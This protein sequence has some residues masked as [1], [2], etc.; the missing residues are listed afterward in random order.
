MNFYERRPLK[1]SIIFLIT[2]ISQNLKK[3]INKNKLNIKLFLFTHICQSQH[4]IYIL[5]TYIYY[6]AITYSRYYRI[7][8]T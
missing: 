2:K 5:V 1:N 6:N 7:V 3:N 4:F 8:G